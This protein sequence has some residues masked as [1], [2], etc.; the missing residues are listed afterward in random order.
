MAANILVLIAAGAVVWWAGTRLSHDADA[1]AA[2]T[3]L[4]HVFI[5]AILLGVATSLP[6]VAATVTAGALGNAQLATGNLLG[7][8]ALQVTVL[9]VADIIESRHGLT[10]QV[11]S[12]SVLVQHVA[13]VL[14]LSLTIAGMAAGEPLSIAGLGLWPIALAVVYV[15]SLVLVWRWEGEER[16]Q[17][18][19]PTPRVGNNAPDN[20]TTDGDSDDAPA[21]RPPVWRLAAL[22]SVILVAGWLVARSGDALSEA[23]PLSG[24][25]VG[26]ALVALT[27]SLP[28]LSTVT[29]SLRLGAYDMA[30]SNIVGTNGLEIALFLVAD[31]SFREGPIIARAGPGGVFLAALAAVL[32]CIFLA[33]LLLRREKTVLR[34]GLD[35]AVVL[36]LY[37]AGLGV[38]AIVS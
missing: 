18:R 7:G 5:G 14:L 24:T 25:F 9:A 19:G 13:L 23:G 10:F 16:W 31:A 29:A 34:V 38:L 12:P 33:G 11:A 35:S 15:L 32:T 21:R 30:V 27:T 36:V 22:G 28:E 4:G 20:D 2:T 8:V 26:A 37:L 17:I 3:G 1:L 6:E